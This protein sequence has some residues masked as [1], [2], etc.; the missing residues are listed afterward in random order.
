M[1]L[2]ELYDV[3]V[4]FPSVDTARAAWA[5]RF[6]TDQPGATLSLHELTGLAGLS[7][8]PMPKDT[9]DTRLV[10]EG[11]D[12]GAAFIGMKLGL[13]DQVAVRSMVTDPATGRS[14]YPD[15]WGPGGRMRMASGLVSDLLA[16]GGHAVVLHQAAQCVKSSE[17]F[18]YE[19]GDL[20]DP[21]VRPYRAWLDF[22]A[23]GAPLECRS[24][25]MPHTF[26]SPNVRCLVSDAG[27]LDLLERSMQAV[28]HAC[29]RIAGANEDPFTLTHTRVPLWFRPGRQVPRPPEPGEDTLGWAATYD[30]DALMITLRSDE[31]AQRHP[32]RLWE[33]AGTQG[34]DAISLDLYSRAVS[35]RLLRG[36]AQGLFLAD[37]IRFAGRDGL[38]PVRILSFDRPGVALY[39]T[40]GFGR[41]PAASGTDELATA[42]AELCVYAP[43]LDERYETVLLGF[44]K[45]AVT[46]PS[47]G[48]LKDFD[49]FPP[50]PDGWAYILV[51]LADIPLSPTRPIALRML[52]P[53]TADEYAGYRTQPDRAA[54]YRATIPTISAVTARWARLFA[55]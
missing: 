18:L 12:P 45:L 35:D 44:G 10:G 47:P 1:S 6:G 55:P 30:R 25:G 37:S 51:P 11:F 3:S 17:R 43:G 36:A 16:L 46:T 29:G 34:P 8:T 50:G 40:A 5:Q 21:A 31:L 48:G 28:E 41:V 52:V 15:P 27:D 26:G 49:G 4:L 13:V 32:A 53:L 54:W 33:A 14:D 2:A 24:Y 9:L 22:V 23:G 20:R 7:A 38:P 42:H 39:V 19:L